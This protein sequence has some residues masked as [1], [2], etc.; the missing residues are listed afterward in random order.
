MQESGGRQSAPRSVRLSPGVAAIQQFSAEV[1]LARPGAGGLIFIS[2]MAGEC[3]PIWS[4]TA[5]GVC[6]GLSSAIS[7][8][9]LVRAILEG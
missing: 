7:R 8:G 4:S 5:R 9:D 1:A 3:M 2:Y 6:Y